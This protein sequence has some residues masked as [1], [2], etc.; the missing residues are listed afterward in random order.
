MKKGIHVHTYFEKCSTEQVK[1]WKNRNHTEHSVTLVY[2]LLIK[3]V[4]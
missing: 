1:Y 4:G 2:S 3:Y